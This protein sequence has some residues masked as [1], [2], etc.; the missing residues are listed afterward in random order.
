MITALSE[1][2]NIVEA[3]MYDYNMFLVSGETGYVQLHLFYYDDTSVPEIEAM[4]SQFMI[5]RIQFLEL[6]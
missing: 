3:H 6:A 2:V 5:P 1:D 4:I